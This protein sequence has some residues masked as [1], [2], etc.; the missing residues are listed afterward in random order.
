MEQHWTIEDMERY[1]KED[2]AEEE[3]LWLEQTGEHLRKCYIC[4]K[5][6]QQFLLSDA[7]TKEFPIR[8]LSALDAIEQILRDEER[9][10]QIL[11][12]FAQSRQEKDARI[13]M[14]H[15]RAGILEPLY[16]NVQALAAVQRT[17]EVTRGEAEPEQ[18]DDLD[19][20]EVVPYQIKYENNALQLFFCSNPFGKTKKIRALA[21]YMYEDRLCCELKEF[22]LQNR[23]EVLTFQI[24]SESTECQI[25]IEEEQES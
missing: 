21:S 6:F 11:D 25:F 12:Y 10:Q 13:L 22:S 14:Q 23:K 24:P 4:Q 15:V 19:I 9:I 20:E 5:K 8:A 2:Y 1:L 18:E 16:I 17:S 7:V 3:L